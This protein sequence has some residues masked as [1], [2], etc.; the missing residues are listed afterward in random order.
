MRNVRDEFDWAVNDA[1]CEACD[2]DIPM[3][4]AITKAARKY[5]FDVSN[6]AAIMGARGAA[7]RKRNRE[8]AELLEC[9]KAFQAEE[10]RKAAKR[11]ARAAKEDREAAIRDCEAKQK[12]DWE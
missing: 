6:M 5:G 4:Q 3:G 8:E 12:V 10:D 11:A 1:L 9:R 7:K 2:S